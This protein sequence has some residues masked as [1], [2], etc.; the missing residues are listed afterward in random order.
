MAEG[1]PVRTAQPEGEWE[2]LGVNS[3]VPS[4]VRPQK[5]P[6]LIDT[7]RLRRSN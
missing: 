7:L 4:R 3:K 6:D 5:T 1:L 2:V